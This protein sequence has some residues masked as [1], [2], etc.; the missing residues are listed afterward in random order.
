M[1]IVKLNR[2]YNMYDCGYTHALRWDS[3]DSKTC[4]RYEKVLGD[5]YGW[6]GYSETRAQWYSGFGSRKG[7]GRRP[8]FIYVRS[9]AMLTTMLLSVTE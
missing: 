8:Y 4:S 9:E 7:G 6:H 1:K 3:W 5:L 2:R